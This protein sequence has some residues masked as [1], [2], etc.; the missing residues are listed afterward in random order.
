M[1]RKTQ[2]Q[3]IPLKREELPPNERELF[4][5]FQNWQA[6]LLKQSVSPDKGALLMQAFENFAR[7]CDQIFAPK[8]DKGLKAVQ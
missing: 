8:P 2:K 5:L 1:A 6:W 7:V 4:D 3:G